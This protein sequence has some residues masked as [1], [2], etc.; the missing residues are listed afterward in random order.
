MTVPRW[1]R[2]LF[3]P[4]AV[5]IGRGIARVVWAGASQLGYDPAALF[6]RAERRLEGA[7]LDRGELAVALD[8]AERQLIDL[9]HQLAQDHIRRADAARRKR[10]QEGKSL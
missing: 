10:L 8:A 9:Y 5:D 3:R 4:S 6:E 1:L 2:R 7:R